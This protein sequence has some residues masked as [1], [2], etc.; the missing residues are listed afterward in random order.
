MLFIERHAPPEAPS[1]ER[2]VLP[3]DLRTKSRLRAKLESGE[4]V[5]LFL[6]RGTVLRG[7]ARLQGNDGRIVEVVAAPERL[8]EARCADPLQL[9]RVA[10]HLGNRHVPV[11]VGAEWLRFE[12]DHVLADMA[13]GLGATVSEITAPFEP[14]SGA[15]AAGHTHGEAASPATIHQ[16]RR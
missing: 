7:G 5:G 11:E 16:Y 1:N 6:E 9:A 2:L 13:R 4:E 3:F 10:Y 8:H 12:A 14:E 15:Y